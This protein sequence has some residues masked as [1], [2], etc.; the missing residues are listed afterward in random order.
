MMAG[1]LMF[2]GDL[3]AIVDEWVALDWLAFFVSTKEFLMKLVSLISLFIL[4]VFLMIACQRDDS[5]DD[6][7][8]DDALRTA[9]KSEL[10][11]VSDDPIDGPITEEDMIQLTSLG[12][13]TFGDLITAGKGI[14]NL[15]GL[16]YATNL[17]KLL[18][19][20]NAIVDISPL[21]G[22]TNLRRL[23][24]SNNTIVDISP[25]T[26]LTNLESLHLEYN[27]IVDIGPLA[28]LTNLEFLYLFD[29]AIVDISP[30][31]GLTN[32]EYLNLKNNAITDISPLTGLTNL[33]KLFLSGNPLS[34]TSINQFIPIIEANETTVF[35][36]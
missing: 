24:L 10:N 12:E 34:T 36:D 23:F 13:G 31:T 26:R 4:S 30:L 17:E 35:Y 19:P 29:N 20:H 32:L 11:I 15:S 2:I 3:S 6:R 27:A 8:P 14:S 22:L 21:A 7:I 18:L 5:F 28:E 1:M 16:E 9:I 25:L 33:K